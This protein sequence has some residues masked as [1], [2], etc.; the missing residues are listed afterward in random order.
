MR[1]ERTTTVGMALM[2]YPKLYMP[3]LTLGLCWRG[4]GHGHVDNGTSG[5][6]DGRDADELCA[7]LNGVLQ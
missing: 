6:G 2:A 7:A 4:R 5:A 3:L 1:I